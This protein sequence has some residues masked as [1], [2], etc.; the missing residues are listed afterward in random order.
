MKTRDEGLQTK[1]L[2]RIDSPLFSE[3]YHVKFHLAI[4]S[5]V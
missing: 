1:P 4:I 2:F 5:F 3:S